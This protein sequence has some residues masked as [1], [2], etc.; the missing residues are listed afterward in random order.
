MS[1]S[2]GETT[3]IT[4][5]A[6]KPSIDVLDEGTILWLG[7]SNGELLEVDIASQ[8]IIETRASAH[9]KKEVI[10]IHRHGYELWTLDDGGKLQVWAPD[11]SGVPNLRNS[12]TT[13]RI[14]NKH[15]Y[16]MVV[17]NQL[18]I[19]HNRTVTVYAPSSNSRTDVLG[20]SISPL[21]R[22]GDITCGT[23]VNSEPDKVFFGHSDGNVSIYSRSTLQCIDVVSVSLYKINSM[24]GVGDY[25]WA[26]FKT[27]MMYVYDVR[28]NPWRAIK[29]WQAHDAPI[30]EAIGDR[31]SIWKV[32]RLQVISLGTDNC[33]KVWDGMLRD[34]WIEAQMAKRDVEF[35][36]FREIKTVI[37][38]WNAGASKPQDLL[39]SSS[40]AA[41]LENVL[42]SIDSPDVII[43]GLQEL[44]DLEDK[45]LTAKTFLKGGKKKRAQAT[46]E[47]MSHQY[48]L[49]QQQFEKSIEKHMPRDQPYVLLHSASLVGLFTCIFIKM[50]ERS[51][52]RN[53]AATTVKRGLGGFHGNKVSA[54]TC[55]FPLPL[56]HHT[57][58]SESRAL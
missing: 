57:Y 32:D 28:T 2:H 42:T 58:F 8:R 34:D 54:F 51:K 35:C 12:P 18:W 40:D 22:T 30:T 3:K 53:L 55:K 37:C 49:W 19:G 16:S 48:K 7:T 36:D 38:T 56:P 11:P 6:F 23:L 39:K 14:P 9:T 46:Q 1:M 31:T 21:K 52:I 13:F 29:D 15:T 26:G 47:K 20:R 45:K 44:V 33:I 50:S 4:A 25:L 27:G 10:K 41:F 17:G 43:F 24:A 5:I